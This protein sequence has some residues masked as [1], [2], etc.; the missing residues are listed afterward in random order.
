M[1]KPKKPK[2]IIE[3]VTLEGKTFRPSDWAERVC[4]SLSTF[5]NRR[6]YYSPLLK[7]S[8]IRGHRC[9]VVDLGI[10]EIHPELFEHIMDFANANKLS[11][12]HEDGSPLE[13]NHEANKDEK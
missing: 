1:P 12:C 3:G 5:K 6:I 8:F 4:G 9:V 10:K 2:I 7:P 11:V 13:S